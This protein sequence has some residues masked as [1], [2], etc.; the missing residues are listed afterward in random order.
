MIRF[1]PIGFTMYCLVVGGSAMGQD[2]DAAASIDEQEVVSEGSPAT[3]STNSITSEKNEVE[4]LEDGTVA[5]ALQRRPDLRFGNVT[6]DGQKSNVSLE[7]MS[8]AAVDTIEVL[9]AVTPDVDADTL[10]GSVSVR[11]KP[12]F[13]QTRRTIQ[14]RITGVYDSGID[15]INPGGSLTLGNSFG[16]KRQWGTLVTVAA[17]DVFYGSDNRLLNWM[18]VDTPD[19]EVLALERMRLDQWHNHERE[20]ELTWVLDRKINESRSLYFRGHYQQDPGTIYNPRLEL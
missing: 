8:S 14:G 1:G 7:S 13:E 3:R 11:S 4:L 18:P 19:G 6:V 12:A 5:D 17:A 15:R 20:L 9:K 2:Q 10:G 16:E